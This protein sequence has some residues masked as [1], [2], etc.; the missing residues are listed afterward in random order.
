MYPLPTFCV[1]QSYTCNV[2]DIDWK[3]IWQYGKTDRVGIHVYAIAKKCQWHKKKISLKLY[4]TNLLKLLYCM[5][6]F[7]SMVVPLICNKS[8]EEV[9][10]D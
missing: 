7:F 6:E 5:L 1:P 8:I 9:N 2:G 4:C 3:G 10:T